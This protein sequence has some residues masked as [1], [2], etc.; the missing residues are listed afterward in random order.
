MVLAVQDTD[1]TANLKFSEMK[2]Y[3]TTETFPHI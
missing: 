1:S 2:V 3:I